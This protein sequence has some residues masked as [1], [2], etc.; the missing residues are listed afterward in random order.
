MLFSHGQLRGKV[1]YRQLREYPVFGGQ[2]TC[3][4]SVSNKTAENS[5]QKLLEH[6]VWHGVCQADFVVDMKTKIPYLID[7]NP[8]FWG[9]LAQ[10]IAAGVDFPNLIYQIA[11]NGDVTPV[12]EFQEGV[13]TRW[14]GGELRG[15]FQH[16]V[17]A[18][19]KISFMHQFFWPGETTVLCDDFSLK[20]PAPFIVWGLDALFRIAKYRKYYSGEYLSGVWE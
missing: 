3:R 19:G 12:T 8:R 2:A 6:F 9:S 4:I 7:I 1:A 16:F 11:I 5:L 14:V 15:F 10:G 13:M 20:D 18:K 17:R